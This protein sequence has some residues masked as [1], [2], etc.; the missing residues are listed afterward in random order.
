MELG[1]ARVRLRE[2]E[3]ALCSAQPQPSRGIAGTRTAR[4]SRGIGSERLPKDQG[5][6]VCVVVAAAD[7]LPR[8]S[9]CCEDKLGGGKWFETHLDS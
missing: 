7:A 2:Q 8:W 1:L 6:Q 3:R 9:I 5:R 4:H